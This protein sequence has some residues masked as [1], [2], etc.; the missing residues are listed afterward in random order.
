MFNTQEQSRV[1]SV[2]KIKDFK[3]CHKTWKI[4]H[5]IQKAGLNLQVTNTAKPA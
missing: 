3:A 2:K 5:T 4:A 1:L